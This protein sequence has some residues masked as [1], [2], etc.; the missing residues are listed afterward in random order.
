MELSNCLPFE[1]VEGVIEAKT[2]EEKKYYWINLLIDSQIA[3]VELVLKQHK[4][5]IE[6]LANAQDKHGRLAMYIAEPKC[7]ELILKY[8]YFLGRYNFVSSVPIHQSET[9]AVFI[10]IDSS[11]TTEERSHVALK[12]MR[13][14]DHF[15]RE[16]NTRVEYNLEKEF[17]I[18]AVASYSHEDCEFLLE[19][20][21]SRNIGD[22]SYLLVMPAADHNLQ[23]LLMHE[24]LAGRN[25]EEIKQI[26]KQLIGCVSHLHS[27]GIVHGDLKRKLCSS[28]LHIHTDVGMFQQR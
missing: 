20:I 16:V 17:L 7:K 1:E 23:N 22:Y 21:R 3:V 24:L 4:K 19:E 14:K 8:L 5:H 18:Q 25:W 26:F 27:R 13:Y 15:D 2:P 28:Y 11:V 9:S 6:S 12:F 10:A